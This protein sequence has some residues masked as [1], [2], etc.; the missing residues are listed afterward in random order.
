MTVKSALHQ[1]LRGVADVPDHHV[2]RSP[3]RQFGVQ[4]YSMNRC[5]TTPSVAALEFT[6]PHR[7]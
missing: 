7:A 2:L 1:V 3:M 4:P 5:C 6:R